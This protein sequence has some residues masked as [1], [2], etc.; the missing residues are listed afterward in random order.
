M[1][2]QG[3]KTCEQYQSMVK[4]TVKMKTCLLFAISM[5]NYSK[6]HRTVYIIL[7]HVNVL[8]EMTLTNTKC[9]KMANGYCLFISNG[10]DI[11][12]EFIDLMSKNE[13]P[14]LLAKKNTF[15]TVVNAKIS[16]AELDNVK[17]IWSR[18]YSEVKYS[19][20]T[21]KV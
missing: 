12:G 21:R 18:S 9:R 1:E 11:N 10:T 13:L 19:A 4:D 16:F 2:A 5:I 8:T 17:K 6:T 20:Y 14:T 7:L 15:I 3:R